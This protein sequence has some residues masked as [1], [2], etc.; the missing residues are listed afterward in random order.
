MA[1]W[2]GPMEDGKR[3]D[4]HNRCDALI[5]SPSDRLL[6][7]GVGGMGARAI[8]GHIYHWCEGV[9]YL[10]GIKIIAP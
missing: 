6:I 1:N 2:L 8:E 5:G 10:R 3:F 7:I 4:K 9:G